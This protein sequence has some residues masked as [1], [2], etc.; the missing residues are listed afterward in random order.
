[1]SLTTDHL[2]R[3]LSPPSDPQRIVSLCPSI[4]ETLY[5][6]GLGAKIVGRTRFCI[7]PEPEIA[8]ATRVGG[9]KG[10][11]YDRLHA[12]RPD[13]IIAEKEENTPEMVERLAQDY[14]VFV[15]TVEQVGDAHRMIRD[16]GTLTGTQSQA[17]ALL[18]DIQA[19]WQH[20]PTLPRALRVAYF[21]WQSPDMVV[22]R[23]TYIQ[24]VLARLGLQNVF[25]SAPGRYPT[26]SE[27][28]LLAAQP[29]LVLLSSEP[30]PFQ[31]QHLARFQALLPQAHVSLVDGEMFSWYGARMHPAAAYL[32]QLIEEWQ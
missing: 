7:H 21:I 4:T 12:L 31:A 32:R 8:Q 23:D 16:L 14:P 17:Q 18:T 28:Q 6:L 5:A 26:V 22:G 15:V 9:T 3:S 13:L 10:I 29:E 2:N 11:K 1:M 25:L 30:F 24:S 27:A 19:A 20:L